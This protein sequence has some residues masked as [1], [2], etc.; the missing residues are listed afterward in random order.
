MS[1]LF[2]H[3]AETRAK[4]EFLTFIILEN[5]DFRVGVVQN[6]TPK[7]IMMYDFGKIHEESLKRK[8]LKYGDIWWWERN[9]SLPI[10]VFI[11][12]SFD[13]YQPMLSGFPKKNISE[14]IGPTFSISELYLKRIKKK[15]IEIINTPKVA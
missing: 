5:N 7:I 15:K 6:E 3:I 10:D 8:F 2:D 4:H 14:I 1:D 13:T 9:Q 12:E 11:G